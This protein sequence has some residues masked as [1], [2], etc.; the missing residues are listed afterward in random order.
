M[1]VIDVRNVQTALPVGLSM[2]L[3]HGVERGSRNGPVVVFPGPATTIYRQPTERVILWEERDANPFFHLMESLWML[4][5][6]RDVKFVAHYVKR[7][8]TFSDDG[9]TLHGAYGWRWC[10]HFGMDQLQTIIS[11]L[12]D[13]PEDRRCVLGM[14]DP[15]VDLGRPGRDVPCNTQAY[16]SVSHEGRLDMTVLNRSNDLVWGAYGAN[17]VHFSILQEFVASSLGR[18]VGTYYQVSNNLHSYLDTLGKVRD[19]APLGELPTHTFERD[20]DPY[21]TGRIKPFPLMS[22]SPAEWD[23]DLDLFMGE[24]P[25]TGFRDPFFRQVVTPMYHAHE[26]WRKRADPDRFAKA[27]EILAQC[28]AEDWR[29]AALEWVTRRWTA[30]LKK[31]AK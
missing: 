3:T 27:T 24:G 11:A 22:T 30:A 10:N 13:N 6:R 31:D 20:Y 18:Q 28:R 12:R 5:G 14:W 7:M 26:A 2:L 15:A 16:F 8:E 21:T 25:V 9:V 17:A 1:F 19:L 29:L 4:A 23:M